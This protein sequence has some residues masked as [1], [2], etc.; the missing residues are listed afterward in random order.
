M[1]IT[2][3]SNPQKSIEKGIPVMSI[4]WIEAV[5]EASLRLNVNG[6]SPDFLEHR[7]PPFTNLQVTTS[8]ITKKE[9]QMIMKLVNEH[10]GTFSGAFQSET[11]DVVVL[12]K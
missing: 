9:K 6:S 8:G 7:L 3:I 12:T 5:W 11:T 1:C 10:G 4:S 2:N